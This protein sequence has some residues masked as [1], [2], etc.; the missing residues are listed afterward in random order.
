M[1]RYSVKD[2]LIYHPNMDSQST[3]QLL[4][5]FENG[6]LAKVQQH[7]T[8]SN[9]NQSIGV[10]GYLPVELSIIFDHKHIFNFLVYDLDANTNVKNKTFESLPFI[11]L[12]YQRNQYL[13]ELL[14]LDISG[15]YE[16]TNDSH[17][18]LMHQ[19][20]LY[21]DVKTVE[22]LLEYF[23]FYRNL[24]DYELKHLLYDKYGCSPLYYACWFGNTQIVDLLLAA[25]STPAREL[26]SDSWSDDDNPSDDL[27][28]I[29]PS[30]FQLGGQ[31]FS[32]DDAS[33]AI[34]I[35]YKRFDCSRLLLTRSLDAPCI[36][37]VSNLNDS[38]ELD[39]WFSSAMKLNCDTEF[40]EMCNLFHE[41][42]L[43]G[44]KF[45]NNLFG[46][47][48]SMTDKVQFNTSGYSKKTFFYN[49]YLSNFLKCLTFMSN[50]DLRKLFSSEK[51]L[52]LFFKSVFL[53]IN[54]VFL[55]Q[56]NWQVLD[57]Y[58]FSRSSNNN[59]NSPS[60][61]VKIFFNRYIIY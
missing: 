4:A 41:L 8:K 28:F 19:A 61:Q 6:N 24:N 54:E 13:F 12:A 29:S 40:V 58:F 15:L 7:L 17:R 1:Q 31:K 60:F 52:E 20:A 10:C 55:T 23:G 46:F 39:S 3:I 48:D 5:A 44:A 56:N 22:T 33:L 50:Y 27:M 38:S 21:G 45:T 59:N 9:V 32:F 14:D 34:S 57:T 16:S 11:A 43:N 2:L 25:S 36:Q 37:Q 18:T 42:I 49:S 47:I 53:K 35:L 26:N 51:A 30:G